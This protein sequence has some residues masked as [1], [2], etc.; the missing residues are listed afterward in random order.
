MSKTNTIKKPCAKCQK[1]YDAPTGKGSN[2]SK[3]CKKCKIIA[4]KE[5]SVKG[6]AKRREKEYPHIDTNEVFYYGY[7]DPLK[8]Y[9]KGFGYV[10][11]LAY[12][13]EKDKVQCHICGRLF[14]NV[15]SH[16]ALYHKIGKEKYKEMTGL[17][18]NTALVGEGTREKLI[19]VHKDTKTFSHKNKTYTQVVD[20]MKKMSAIARKNEKAGKKRKNPW[21]MEKRNKE[22]VCPDQLI[23]RISRLTEKLGERPSAKRYAQEYGSFQSVITV[24]GTWNKALEI[25]GIKTYT[26]Q[27]GERSD[28]KYLLEYM[29]MFYKKHGRTPRHS[30]MLRGLLPRHQIYCKVFGTLNKA[31][32]LAGVPVLLRVGGYK[33]YEEAI[34]PKK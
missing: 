22:G 33:N 19:L 30:D 4:R 6:E 26:E 29:R 5:Y 25:A 27:K 13:K 8:R 2:R 1:D 11:V 7:K 32:Q 18:Q 10:G 23:D 16:A 28:P 20:H 14:K 31:R 17:S 15:G 24:F 21:S 9:A 12:N 34:I 3:Y